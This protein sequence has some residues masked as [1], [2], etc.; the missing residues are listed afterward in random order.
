MYHDWI[1]DD[2]LA[3]VERWKRH[4]LSNKQIA[5]NIGITE[6]TF[7]QWVKRFSEFAEAIKK[8][9]EVI[10]CELENALIKRAKGYDV[11]E[12]NS[13]YDR[14]GNEVKRESIRHIPPDTTALI[15][16]LKNMD[17]QNW[18]DRRET[19]L[20]GAVQ[21]VPDKLLFVSAEDNDDENGES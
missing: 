13:F 2:G 11:T 14:D 9:R 5:D 3:T 12:S 17:A 16:A 6:E 4:G 19:A 1:T 21:T 7:Y 20:S 10:V 8:G 18:R 15:F